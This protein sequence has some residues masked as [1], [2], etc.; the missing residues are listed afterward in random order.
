MLTWLWIVTLFI[1]LIIALC[2][3][4]YVFGKRNYLRHCKKR[5]YPKRMGE[6]HL[7][8]RGDDLFNLFY[9]DI[10]AAKTSIHILFY[11]VKG[12]QFSKNFL[13]LLAQKAVEGVE[14]RLLMDWMGSHSVSK[15][16]M[17]QL[18]SIG[19]EVEFCNRPHFPFLFFT[20]Q[21]R[22]HRKCSVID[23]KIGYVGGYNVGKEYIDKDPILSPWR[24]YCFRFLGESVKD[25]QQEF[26]INW[27]RATSQPLTLQYSPEAVNGLMV[28]RF[29]PTEGKYLE[30]VICG[31]IDC[32]KERIY[33]GTPY[34]IPSNKVLERLL[35]ASKRGVTLKI[36]V[37]EK[38]DHILVK[39]ASFRYFRR[40]LSSGAEVYQYLNGFYHAKVM[41]IDQS[42]CQT[43]TANFDRR[44]FF[45]N[46]ELNCYIYDQDFIK[47]ITKV[48]EKD[49]LDSHQLS[50]EELHNTSLGTKIKEFCANAMANIL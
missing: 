4:D 44:S 15:S 41:I 21:Q 49:I 12:D 17:K 26:S 47:R 2:T 24:D 7:I 22:N 30:E 46:H 23:G 28:H 25:I 40:L 8:T 16:L 1:L 14:V 42:I 39:E 48:V 3:A 38:A 18:K 5:E 32:A 11:I 19:A 29:F 6:I 34:F 9:S 43:G 27:E 13:E 37:P 20:L 33:I 35:F 10:K 36:L 50:I 45:L 31:L